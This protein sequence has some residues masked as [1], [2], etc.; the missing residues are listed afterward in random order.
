M[1]TAKGWKF[2]LEIQ[3]WGLVSKNTSQKEWHDSNR[4]FNRSVGGRGEGPLINLGGGKKITIPPRQWH[5]SRL[6]R[7]EI[8]PKPCT[9]ASLA[10][11]AFS[12]NF[13]RR[14]NPRRFI[15]HRGSFTRGKRPVIINPFS[16]LLRTRRTI[17]Q[18]ETI[19][20]WNRPRWWEKIS[21]LFFFAKS[22]RIPLDSVFKKKES[23]GQSPRLS[24]LSKRARPR[25]D[26]DISI[27]PRAF[28][29]RFEI[30]TGFS[31]RSRVFRSKRR[32]NGEIP[33][34][35]GKFSTRNYIRSIEK[36]GRP[37]RNDEKWKFF[38]GGGGRN[39]E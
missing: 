31:P 20:A 3:G 26:L 5:E 17:A 4:R 12:L 13:H 8:V 18:A 1:V 15:L 11:A 35:A 32:F 14:R 30:P 22:V 19:L 23:H 9:L 37:V 21:A 34:L 33:P 38:I 7:L 6:I 29:P 28:F 25:R 2:R 27:G 36:N 10:G 24:P 16:T 39:V